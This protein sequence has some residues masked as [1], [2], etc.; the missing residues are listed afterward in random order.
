MNKRWL[1]IAAAAVVVIIVVALLLSARA[2]SRAGAAFQTEELATGSL[3]AV[4]GATGTV[5]ANQAATLAFQTTGTIDR[6]LTQTGE[7][8]GKDEVLATLERTSLSPSII[9]AQADL[10]EAERALEDV[11]ASNTAKAQ[12]ELALANAQDALDDAEYR[13]RVQQEGYRASPETIR[14]AEAKL[15]L[16]NE[17]VE[18]YQTIYD[19]SKGESPKALALVNLHGAEERRDTALRELNWYKGKPT[20][21]DQ[22]ILDAELAV[23]KATFEDA[24]RAYERVKDGPNEDDVAVAQARVDA[25]RASLEMAQVSAPFAG[26]ITEVDVATGDLVSSGNTAFRI[27]DLASLYLDLQISEVDLSSVK[28]GPS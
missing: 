11:T 27:D 14:A 25:A 7:A 21:N 6:V 16:A 3:T 9:L 23:A 15:L 13:W 26:T 12:A 4:V 8:V 2:R 1:W 5:H 18:H 20:E 19:R 28:V 10:V 24:Q 22:A 17:E